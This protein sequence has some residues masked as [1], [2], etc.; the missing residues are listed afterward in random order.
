MATSGDR[1]QR[2][3]RWA[4]RTGVRRR[5]RPGLLRLV[6]QGLRRNGTVLRAWWTRAVQRPAGEGFESRVA[7]ARRSMGGGVYSSVGRNLDSS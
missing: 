7:R 4:A 6:N 1:L 5:S 2:G 3:R